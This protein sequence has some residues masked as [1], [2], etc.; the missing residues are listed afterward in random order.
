MQYGGVLDGV[1]RA[2]CGCCALG[3]PGCGIGCDDGHAPKDKVGLHQ[4][5]QATELEGIF[6]SRARTNSPAF[7]HRKAGELAPAGYVDALGDEDDS[8]E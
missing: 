3:R 2:P 1:N 6:R 7:R 5:D 8:D 4:G